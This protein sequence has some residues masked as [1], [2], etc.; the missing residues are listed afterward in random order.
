[1]T[2]SRGTDNQS[3][4]ARRAMLADLLR[5][6]AQSPREADRPAANSL[7]ENQRGMWFLQQLA[8]TSA[9]YNVAFA[10]SIVS[11]LDVEALR[12]ALQRLVDRHAILRTTYRLEGGVP[13]QVVNGQKP[14]DFAS[15][16]AAQWDDDE[17]RRRVA[18][19]TQEPFDLERGPVSRARLFVVRAVHVLPL[20]FHHIASTV[21]H[22]AVPD[23]LRTA[24]QAAAGGDR[25]AAAAPATEYRDF[26]RWQAEMLRRTMSAA[27]GTSIRR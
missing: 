9:A 27:H 21:V 5:A 10:V 8:P 18:A 3:A 14:I 24:Y 19:A 7:S 1:M 13:V 26:V 2:A 23:E 22:V 11:P 20:V 16:P 6:R 15:V 25:A 12:E 4:E 17:L